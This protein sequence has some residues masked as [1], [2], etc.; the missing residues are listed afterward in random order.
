MF[1]ECRNA[2]HV[3][4]HLL[5]DTKNQRLSRLLFRLSSKLRQ[6]HGDQNQKLRSPAESAEFYAEAAAGGAWFS[7]L[8]E[9]LA[10]VRDPEHLRFIGFR[11]ELGASV[12]HISL[13]SAAM[14]EEDQFAL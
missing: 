12:S 6:W 13:E 11:L 9:T 14:A 8:V 10:M 7:T 4:I 3:S 2:M 1:R 5:G